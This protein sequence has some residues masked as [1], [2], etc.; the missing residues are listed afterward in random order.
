ML[1][2]KFFQLL[3]LKSRK[4]M[5]NLKFQKGISPI[6]AVILLAVIL[7]G[8][9]AY[10]FGQQQVKQ[11][12]KPSVAD[13][14][15]KWKTYTNDRYKYEFKY[16]ATHDIAA[17][18]NNEVEISPV[19]SVCLK[20]DCAFFS[21]NSYEDKNNLSITDWLMNIRPDLYNAK[22][23]S[24]QDIIINNYDAI[25]ISRELDVSYYLI[26]NSNINDIGFGYSSKLG[27][28]ILSTF[29][30]TNQNQTIDASTWKTYTNTQYGFSIKYPEELET[31][32]T[33]E[34][35]L[36]NFSFYKKGEAPAPDTEGPGGPNSL[37]EG[38]LAPVDSQKLTRLEPNSETSINPDNPFQLSSTYLSLFMSPRAI[39]CDLKQT[40]KVLIKEYSNKK[41]YTFYLQSYR[42]EASLSS[43]S[44]TLQN[45]KTECPKYFKEK[46]N[47]Q[48]LEPG[49]KQFDLVAKSLKFL[50]K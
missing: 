37:F 40:A 30:F 23:D 48:K 43:I 11:I 25:K 10:Y 5:K 15:A 49:V 13:E 35:D 22:T 7:I 8:G 12:S 36:V 6:I 19:I 16:P 33:V 44:L 3:N 46:E 47:I 27:A 17:F 14:T 50:N 4:S 1:I 45:W 31:I 41:D 39:T 28:Q 38:S 9:G 2:G 32:K 20:G 42:T 24:K 18:G 34:G 29:K 26:H 21:V